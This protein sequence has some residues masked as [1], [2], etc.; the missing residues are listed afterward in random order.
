MLYFKQRRD[1]RAWLNVP[2]SKS[3]VRVIVPGVRIPLPPPLNSTT[4]KLSNYQT[5]KL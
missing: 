5:V 2:D 1:D 4:I 3:G